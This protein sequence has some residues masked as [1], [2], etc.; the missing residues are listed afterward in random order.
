MNKDIINKFIKL[1][2]IKNTYELNLNYILEL[3]SASNLCIKYLKL[4][5]EIIH[6][7]G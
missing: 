2:V 7:E 4:H 3:K 5:M 6:Y 1:I